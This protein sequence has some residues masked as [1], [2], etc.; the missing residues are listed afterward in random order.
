[1]L[2]L[3][4]FLILVLFGPLLLLSYRWRLEARGEP[5]SKLNDILNG[6]FPPVD[7]HGIFQVV[8]KLLVEQRL[9]LQLKDGM[10]KVIT[11]VLNI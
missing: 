11:N 5:R 4:V 10:R 7:D 6:R 2:L 1:M 8:D 3:F 9:V